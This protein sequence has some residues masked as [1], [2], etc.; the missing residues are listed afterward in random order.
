MRKFIVLSIVLLML[1]GFAIT[2]S[3][4]EVAVDIKPQS[5]PNPLNVKSK[6]VLPVAILGTEDFDVTQIDT[7]TI[8]IMEVVPLRW[9]L[10]DVATPYESEPLP[11]SLTDV[12]EPCLNCIEE[13]SDG[14]LDLTLKFDIQEIVIALGEV[15]DG[16]CLSLTLTGNLLEEF[17][18]TPIVGE[19]VIFI[20][21]KGK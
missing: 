5:C 18:G 19:D 14:F 3:A 13:G 4:M 12:P 15:F 21:Q 2:S 8:A 1:A 7:T 20:I 17:G 10:E 9:A 11:S 6:G 16:D